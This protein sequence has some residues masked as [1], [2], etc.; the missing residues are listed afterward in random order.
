MN[1]EGVS[2]RLKKIQYAAPYTYRG[3]ECVLVIK[4]ALQVEGPTGD[5]LLQDDD[6]LVVNSGDLHSYTGQGDH[7]VLILQISDDFLRS[8]CGELS[9]TR[10]S[11][12]RAAEA[13]DRFTRLKRQMTQLFI[14]YLKDRQTGFLA[15]LFHFLDSLD[16]DFREWS[17]A[18]VSDRDSQDMDRVLDYLNASYSQRLTLS[19]AAALAYMSPQAFSKA[20]KRRVGVG[21]LAYLSQIRTEHAAVEL[22]YTRNS[23]TQVAA[24]NGFASNKAL[25]AAFR[26]YYGMTP[27]AYRRQKAAL[28]E[29]RPSGEQDITDQLATDPM[30]FLGAV[31]ADSVSDGKRTGGFQITCRASS[32][33]EEGPLFSFDKLIAVDQGLASIA[34]RDIQ[35]TLEIA[36]RE[37]G[38]DY[39]QIND[40]DLTGDF[41]DLSPFW[42]MFRGE[43][44]IIGSTPVSE[45]VA[46][47]C[48]LELALYLRIDFSRVLSAYG[49]DVTPFFSRLTFF[50][51]VLKDFP[52]RDYVQKTR[53]EF[54][55]SDANHRTTFLPFFRQ[56]ARQ[57][58]AVIP[59]GVGLYLVPWIA[60]E[61]PEGVGDLIC[62]AALEIPG[63]APAPGVDL[64]TLQD[65]HFEARFAAARATVKNLGGPDI[66][67]VVTRWNVIDVDSPLEAGTFFRSA[68]ILQALLSLRGTV[69]GLSFPCQTFSSEFSTANLALFALYRL[70][71]PAF[72]VLEVVRRLQGEPLL[73]SRWAVVTRPKPREYT[74]ALLCPSYAD[75]S[76]SLDRHFVERETVEID[77]AL[78]DLEAGLYCIKRLTYDKDRSGIFGR[79]QSLG[80]VD[81]NDPDVLRYLEGTVQ[82]DLY[83]YTQHAENSLTF[84]A[85]VPFNCIVLFHARLEEKMPEEE[86]RDS[87]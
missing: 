24:D 54:A 69:Q 81:F 79:V 27:G 16:R 23:V 52:D 34:S 5:V 73:L 63:L 78:N 15:M 68:I 38:F 13:A 40:F 2:I 8:R 20:F 26:R 33:S 11:C 85:T 28:R 41:N 60:E 80:A 29:T 43:S 25:T 35:E 44:C 21:F 30:E 53:F 55:C 45:L 50:L 87:F 1:I 49:Q 75:P 3:L 37:I 48:R 31:R 9:G 82:P 66:P 64:Q 58:N 4:G 84:R 61:P 56:A 36:Q 17:P 12:A 59:E 72:Y 62:F 42:K 10:F 14:L 7:A 32:V 74:A 71:R 46:R 70:K 51:R 22:L 67:F 77:L 76:L 19:D 39:V 57:I 65:Q 86:I 18:P 47:Y 83:L 6:L